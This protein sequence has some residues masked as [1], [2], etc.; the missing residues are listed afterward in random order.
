[1]FWSWHVLNS[2]RLVPTQL[3]AMCVRWGG[4]WPAN[5]RIQHSDNGPSVEMILLKM[6][7]MSKPHRSYLPLRYN[8]L[9]DSPIVSLLSVTPFNGIRVKYILQHR[10]LRSL[11]L[12]R[13][14]YMLSVPSLQ[15]AVVWWKPGYSIRIYIIPKQQKSD[16]WHSKAILTCI[17]VIGEW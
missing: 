10:G 17:T 15:L 7:I 12:I 6:Q 11:M 9:S 1:M 3:T 13:C 2:F 4:Q 8:R 16:N 5:L 14:F